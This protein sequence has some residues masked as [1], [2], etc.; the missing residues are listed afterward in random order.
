MW[1]QYRTILIRPISLVISRPVDARGAM[2]G[3]GVA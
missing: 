1:Q 3:R 2:G